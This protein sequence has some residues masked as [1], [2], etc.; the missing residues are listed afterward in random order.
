M[1]LTGSSKRHGKGQL[2]GLYSRL[3]PLVLDGGLIA[4]TLAAAAR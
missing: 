3:G 1:T 4:F 2:A